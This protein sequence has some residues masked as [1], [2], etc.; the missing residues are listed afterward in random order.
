MYLI[1]GILG[2]LIG[3]LFLFVRQ[4]IYT[5]EH[6]L[7][8]LSD[9]IQAIA[10]LNVQHTIKDED[11]AEEDEDEDEEDEDE[12]EEDEDEE[13]EVED[14]K[15]IFKTINLEPLQPLKFEFNLAHVEPAFEHLEPALEYIESKLE[16]VEPAFEHLEPALEYIESKLEHVEPA[17]EHLEPALEYLESKLE[18]VEPALDFKVITLER[19]VSDEIYEK[20]TVKE[21]KEKVAEVDGPKFKTKKEM[22][23]F[24]KSR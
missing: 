6:R 13:D 7:N 10:G 18:H 21:L 15:V 3:L 5:F 22:V 8:L 20:M 1:V 11:E 23:D 19:V 9:T 2:L 24:L 17:F 14:D 16:H 12:D 4:K